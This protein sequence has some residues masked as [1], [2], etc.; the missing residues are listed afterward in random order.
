MIKT[1]VSDFLVTDTGAVAD[2]Q[3][4]YD[5]GELTLGIPASNVVDH[6]IQ[7]ESQP[8]NTIKN[9]IDEDSEGMVKLRNYIYTE[10]LYP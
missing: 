5:E 3:M 2:H 6:G 7:V 10:I 4:I 9:N 1:L 8:E